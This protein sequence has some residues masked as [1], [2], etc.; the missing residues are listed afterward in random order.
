MYNGIQHPKTIPPK[1]TISYKK[2]KRINEITFKHN[3][4]NA[5]SNFPKEDYLEQA[6]NYCNKAL[7]DTMENQAPLKTKTLKPNISPARM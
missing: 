4:E 6:V 5:L 2:L 3:L 7:N 1:K